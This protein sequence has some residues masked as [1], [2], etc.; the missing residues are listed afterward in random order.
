[1]ATQSLRARFGIPPNAF[2]A[3]NAGSFYQAKGQVLIP[4]AAA[5]LPD[6]HWLIAGEGPLR[7]A[8]EAA[9]QRHGVRDRVHMLGWLADARVMLPELAVF[10]STS[11]D[12][13]LGNVVLEAMAARVPVI[14]ADAGG[15]AEIL[16]PVQRE[17]NVLFQPRDARALADAITR[18]RNADVCS[19]VLDAQ[20]ARIGDFDIARTAAATRAL[21]HEVA[22]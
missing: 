5:L 6:V 2:V 1:S 4:E 18:L 14:A 16:Q 8:L 11:V 15:P 21:Y 19:T 7:A 13:A 12:D 10:V 20:D 17:A 22:R 9:I 3:G